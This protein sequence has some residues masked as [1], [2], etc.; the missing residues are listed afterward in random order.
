MSQLVEALSSN[1]E[2]LREHTRL[3]LRA[4]EWETGGKAESRLLSGSDI[5][6]AK[7]WAAQRP[8]DAPEPTALHVEFIRASEEAQ[9]ARLAVQRR[10]LE[11]SASEGIA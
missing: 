10:Q 5:V 3:L 9:D 6:A 11:E 1:L 8:K 7:A 2:W 4:T